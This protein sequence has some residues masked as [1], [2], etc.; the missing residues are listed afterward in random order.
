M[1]WVTE[2]RHEPLIH[3]SEF[4]SL[5]PGVHRVSYPEKTLLVRDGDRSDFVLF[6]IEGYAKSVIHRP[7]CILGI[8]RPGLL[9]GELAAL[10]SRPRSADLVALTD[11][12]ALFIPA[13]TFIKRI[14]GGGPLAV[15]V[16]QRLAERVQAFGERVES[17]TGAEQKLARAVLDIIQSGIAANTGDGLELTGF[18]QRDLASLAGIPRESVSAIL[19]P[20]K[21]KGAVTTGRYRITIHDPGHFEA[22]AQRVDHAL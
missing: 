8:H 18:N 2:Q 7:E 13:D 19:K 14:A 11:I 21:A 1:S 3:E 5:G 12:E 22:I 20:L 17:I 15:A 4:D 6:L 10:T 9:V 16:T